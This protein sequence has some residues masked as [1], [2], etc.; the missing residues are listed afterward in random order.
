VH[1]F[2]LYELLIS[3]I[4]FCSFVRFSGG[5]ISVSYKATISQFGAREFRVLRVFLIVCFTSDV[6]RTFDPFT[7]TIT[8]DSIVVWYDIAVWL[9]FREGIAV[10][11]LL[12]SFLVWYV[13][14]QMQ[15]WEWPVDLKG[16]FQF[17]WILTSHLQASLLCSLP[18]SECSQI[19]LSVGMY[20]LSSNL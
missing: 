5:R 9:F 7:D 14:G 13:K 20:V 6:S 2:F 10:N 15:S 12:I 1:C 17:L 18:S 8:D 3:Q 19:Y 11:K 16:I 4:F